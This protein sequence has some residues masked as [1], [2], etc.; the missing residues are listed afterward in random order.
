MLGR[1]P[2]PYSAAACGSALLVSFLTPPLSPCVQ[3]DWCVVDAEEG[4]KVFRKG[5]M[6]CRGAVCGASA[7]VGASRNEP[8]HGRFFFSGFFSIFFFHFRVSFRV[9]G[10]L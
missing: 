7:A 9:S 3:V 10:V 4:W 6:P 8:Y 5:P 2:L 1:A